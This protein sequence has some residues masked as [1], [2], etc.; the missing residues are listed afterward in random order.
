MF[1]REPP[2]SQSCPLTCA[3]SLWN[4]NRTTPSVLTACALRIGITVRTQNAGRH[5]APDPMELSGFLGDHSGLVPDPKDGDLP[6]Y[7]KDRDS[8]KKYESLFLTRFRFISSLKLET[9]VS[10]PTT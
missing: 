8:L 2:R 6:L 9:A 1:K 4:W 10:I 5:R 3:T 7:K